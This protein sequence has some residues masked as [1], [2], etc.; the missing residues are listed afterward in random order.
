[1][2]KN[3][4]SN[5]DFKINKEYWSEKDPEESLAIRNKNLLTVNNIL[6]EKKYFSF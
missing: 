5:Q 2:N 3:F 6:N 1:M 4:W